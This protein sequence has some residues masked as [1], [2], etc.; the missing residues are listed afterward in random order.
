MVLQAGDS[1]EVPAAAERVAET[2]KLVVPLGDLRPVPVAI[3]RN[4]GA[5]HLADG[6]DASAHQPPHLTA[7]AGELMFLRLVDQKSD[8]GVESQIEKPGAG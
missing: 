5:L 3:E 4:P 1:L 6:D 8:D 2:R 7:P